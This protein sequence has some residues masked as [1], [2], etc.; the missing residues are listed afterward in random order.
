MTKFIVSLLLF[1]L[2][3][4]AIALGLTFSQ[5]VA[6]KPVAADDTI[7]FTSAINAD[8][9]GL[10]PL[11][12]FTTRAGD[13]LPYRHY[14]GPADD[15]RIVFLVHGS[16]WHGMQFHPMAEVLT[17]AGIG[18]VILPD[19]RGHGFS[20]ER[21]GDVDYIGQMEDDLADLVTHLKADQGL[22]GPVIM[23]GHSSGGGL[24]VRFAGGEHGKLADG[25]ILMAPF[26]KYDAPTTRPDSGGWA[27]VATRRIIGLSMLN[28]VGITALN[29]LPII[30]FNM[31]QSVLD[32]D[33]GDTATTQY[34]YRLNTGF[35]PRMDF[36]ADLAAMEQPFLLIAGSDDESF[37]A[38]RYEAVI[39]AQTDSGIYAIIEGID[40]I[41][42]TTEPEPINAVTNWIERFSGK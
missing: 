1:P 28:T 5:S 35:A 14:R 22:S 37:Y 9:A 39:S 16:S 25:Y 6:P 3:Y 27:N 23:G 4:F 36:E 12:E 21:R 38:D 34:S 19:L 33:L 41:G 7:D 20:P 15:T 40:H 10:Q 2:I 30:A 17:A 31:P 29:H 13:T 24:M 18:H 42:V 26:L 32:G 8:Y 11:Q